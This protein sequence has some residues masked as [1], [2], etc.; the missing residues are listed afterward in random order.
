MRETGSKGGKE[1]GK[2]EKKKEFIFSPFLPPKMH[3]P[4]FQQ[5]H[6]T[7]ANQPGIDQVTDGRWL[8]K[9]KE[10]RHILQCNRSGTFSNCLYCVLYCVNAIRWSTER[11]E[12]MHECMNWIFTP[13]LIFSLR[14]FQTVFFYAE[15]LQYFFYILFLFFS[16]S[17]NHCFTCLIFRV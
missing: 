17:V 11:L 2:G 12:W 14:S 15:V 4:P 10:W 8:H 5:Q 6:L 9:C 13:V 16:E 7:S 3:F 1:K